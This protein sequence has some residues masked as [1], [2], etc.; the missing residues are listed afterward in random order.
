[1]LSRETGEQIA[2][3]QRELVRIGM[4]QARRVGDRLPGKTWSGRRADRR[5]SGPRSPTWPPP[6]RHRGVVVLD[7]R[8]RLEWHEPH[9]VGAFHIPIHELLGR[10][11]EVPEGE[12]WVHC[13]AGY[14]ASIAASILAAAGTHV[15]AIDDSFAEQATAL[16]ACRSSQSTCTGAI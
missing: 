13:A 7:V 4:D 12:V 2:E 6:R 14:R 8:R 11:A 5:W 3:A 9:V 15:V 1:M 10:V 16:P